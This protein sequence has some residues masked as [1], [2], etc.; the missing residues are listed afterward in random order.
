MTFINRTIICERDSRSLTLRVIEA[1]D[2]YD[3]VVEAAQ[4]AEQAALDASA[5]ALAATEAAGEAQQAAQEAVEYGKYIVSDMP[6]LMA[7]TEE[8][9][10]GDTISL[11]AEGYAFEVVSGAPSLVTASGV[12]LRPLP[13][14]GRIA[15]G[16][17]G[18]LGIGDE[19]A[20]LQAW[21]QW[22]F[23]QGY[24]LDLEGKAV[25]VSRVDFT[26]D[27]AMENGTIVSN[28]TAPD[29]GVGGGFQMDVALMFEGVEIGVVDVTADFFTGQAFLDLSDASAVQ[30]GDLLHVNSSRLID[31]DHRGQWAEGQMVKVIGKTGNRVHLDATMCYTGKANLAV[32]GTITGVAG[33]RYSVDLSDMMPGALR[34]RQIRLTVTSGAGAGESRFIVAT[35]GSSSVRHSGSMPGERDRLPWPATVQVGDSYE[36]S[37]RTIAT[38][39]RPAKVRLENMTI[40][41]EQINTFAEGDQGFRGVRL[42]NCDSPVVRNCKIDNF[43]ATNLHLARCYRPLVEN[44]EVNGANL[45]HT[46]SNGTG[47]G[48][49][50]E[51]CSQP[52]IRNVRG[53][54][55]RRV[56]DISGA[57]GYSEY[58]EC[59]NVV[60]IGGGKTYTGLD[61]FPDGPQQQSIVGSHGSGRFT[62]YQNCMG[63][64]CFGGLNLRGREEVA[65]DYAHF[66]C[67]DRI[68]NINYT[69][70]ITIDGV[71]YSDTFTE[72]DRGAEGRRV[73]GSA[74]VSKR[75]LSV[76]YIDF[77]E[78]FTGRVITTIRNVRA[79]SVRRWAA[80]L[81][82]AG[83]DIRNLVFEN[84]HVSATD[85]GDPLAENFEFLLTG[86]GATIRDC[87]FSNCSYTLQNGAEYSGINALFRVPASYEPPMGG[88]FKVD[89]WH[90]ARLDQNAVI[91]FP[92]G[93]PTA[94]VDLRNVRTGSGRP[95]CSGLMVDADTAGEMDGA[96]NA[97]NIAVL[98][99]S[100]SSGGSTPSGSF[101]LHLGAAAARL[102]VANN[103]GG[104][105]T[106]RIRIS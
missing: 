97:V 34:D 42:R 10:S 66:G 14:D 96:A 74:D 13:R 67:A 51:V 30:I 48:V 78:P 5:A 57:G 2:G 65:T 68:I 19:T 15:A 69:S 101:G 60:G 9:S 91:R 82:G 72:D 63:I 31:T 79:K 53:A 36:Y 62:R 102:S 81:N 33:N 76:A 54:N 106:F 90:I 8:F 17:V 52:M 23:D 70:G 77:T 38:I 50:V 64:D 104:T 55:C 88:S 95:R 99:A 58:G 83:A 45:A 7:N 61:F 32:T 93:T 24:G 11:R 27:A 49:S 26:G 73:I 25:T 37:W 71:T 22:A 12:H 1:L 3:T 80:Q 100:F 6:A 94:T 103:T 85:E 43:C 92:W 28:K 75:P 35:F 41:R 105:Q 39:Y 46:T 87:V 44:C 47:Y 18:L 4:Q 84:W 98:A 16:Q 29:G 21:G 56:V 86:G 89:D 20:S 40:T 59:T